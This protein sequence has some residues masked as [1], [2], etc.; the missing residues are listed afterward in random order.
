MK[1]PS[2]KLVCNA[3]DCGAKFN[4]DYRL[5]N[6]R[7]QHGGGNMPFE[8]VDA[9]RNPF[10]TAKHGIYVLVKVKQRLEEISGKIFQQE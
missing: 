5:Q 1:G 7:K 8:T 2:T 10:E 9:P 6:N 3:K 4:S